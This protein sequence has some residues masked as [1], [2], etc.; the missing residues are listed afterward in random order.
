M[1]RRDFVMGAAAAA[2]GGVA[3]ADALPRRIVLAS[4]LTD[5]DHFAARWL[6]LIYTEAFRR[7]AVELE[8]RAFPAA[9]ASAE[10]AAGNVDGEMVRSYEYQD[11]QP[12]LLRVPEPTIYVTTASYAHR[13]GVNPAPGWVGLR[14]TPYRVEYRAG[15]SV[16]G[17]KLAALVPAGLLSSVNTAQLGLR[18]LALDRTDLYVDNMEVAEPLLATGEFRKLGIRQASVIERMPMYAYLN[19]NHAALA[20]RLGAVLKRMRASGQIERYRQQALMEQPAPI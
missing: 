4:L 17:N 5:S 14:A 16:M 1:R 9:R 2:T 15:Y 11:L 12:G 13:P 8:I 6:A 20:P 3:F 19:R 18:K 10:A 7:L